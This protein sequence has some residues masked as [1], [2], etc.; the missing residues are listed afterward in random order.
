MKILVALALLCA[1]LT[2]CALTDWSAYEEFTPPSRLLKKSLADGF[3][4]SIVAI[5][6]RQFDLDGAVVLQFGR[7]GA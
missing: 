1:G 4:D 5:V 3:E 2:G 7:S 6:E